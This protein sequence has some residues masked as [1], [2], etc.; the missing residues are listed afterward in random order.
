VRYRRAMTCPLLRRRCNVTS[1]QVGSVYGWVFAVHHH[2]NRSLVSLC[3]GALPA[4]G[5]IPYPNWSRL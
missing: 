5:E 2:A 3:H 4:N 1:H